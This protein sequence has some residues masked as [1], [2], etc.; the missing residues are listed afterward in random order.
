MLW[1]PTYCAGFSAWKKAG[2]SRGLITR[3]PRIWAAMITAARRLL[4]TP[5]PTLGRDASAAAQT[6]AAR[7]KGS[8]PASAVGRMTP[9]SRADRLGVAAGAHL[10]PDR[11]CLWRSPPVQSQPASGLFGAVS[12]ALPATHDGPLR[13]SD[14]CLPKNRLWPWPWRPRL[15]PANLAQMITV[16]RG[17]AVSRIGTVARP[18]AAASGLGE[19]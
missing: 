15:P 18:Q 8:C 3:F 17:G 19:G 10:A 16:H 14:L 11:S 4:R 12:P 6:G 7:C 2:S 9:G 13:P 5:C 1:S